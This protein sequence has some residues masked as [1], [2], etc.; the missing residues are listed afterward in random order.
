MK[1]RNF[2]Q[3]LA[4]DAA[5]PFTQ[6]LASAANNYQVGIG[7]STTD[8]YG[9]TQR[10]IA[11]S[12]QWPEMSGKTVMIK[13]NLVSPRLSSTGCTTDPQV[14]RAVVDQALAA[15]ADQ[16]IIGEGGVGIPPANFTAC[17]YSF[18]GTY[19]SKVQLMDF[20]AQA[21]SL[22]RIPNGLTYFEV[23][24]PTPTVQA[25]LVF[26]SVGKMKTHVNAGAS[27]SMK[28]VFGIASPKYYLVPNQLARMDCH[29]RGID[30][31]IIDMNLARPVSYSVIDGVW[32]MEG[33]GPLTGTP[34]QAGVVLAGLNPVAV[35]RVG[36]DFMKIPQFQIPHLSYAYQ[37]GL[38][39]I[40][41][42]GVTVAGDPYTPIP[43]VRAK[44]SPIVWRPASV[45]N[46]VSLATNQTVK[47]TYSIPVACNVSVQIIKDNDAAPGITVV[48]ALQNWTETPAGLSNI[49]W[50][51]K[52]NTGAKVAP[53]IYMARVI[54]TF[55]GGGGLNYA[56]GWI[57]V[58]A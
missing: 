1:R 23:Y 10:A 49:V 2:L 43:F 35:D 15:G 47:I 9:A 45:P 7:V 32:A 29:L 41:T 11:G 58:N 14:T 33:N 22:V 34:I 53:G 13:P 6:R 24:L 46:P 12:G 50:D 37:K 48:R 17:G 54:T 51:C 39:P 38:G 26:I 52:D 36:L 56:T 5:L 19:N 28:N 57:V 25:G 18:F 21:I 55:G 16:V 8:P 30:Q 3:F 42:S 20:G 40:D 31:S 4:A 27:L 44:T